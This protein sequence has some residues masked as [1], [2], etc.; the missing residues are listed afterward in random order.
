MFT[1]KQPINF[2]ASEG[3]NKKYHRLKK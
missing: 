2:L 3:I 1:I